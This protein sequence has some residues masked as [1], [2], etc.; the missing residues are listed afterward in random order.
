MKA[1]VFANGV[2][3][4][5]AAI[6]NAL[7]DAAD[8]RIVCANGG[9]L[10]ARAL[11]LTPDIIIGDLDSLTPAQANDFRA[12]GCLVIAAPA[13][14][15][16]TDLELAL[17]HCRDIGAEDVTIV[18]ALGGRIDQ[19]LANVLLLTLPGV[20]GMSLTL[21]DGGQTAR[22]LLPGAHEVFG[23]AGDTLSLIPL[24]DSVDGVT[25]QNLRYPLS[26]ESLPQGPARGIS[27]VM[28][29]DRAE[30]GFRRGK[31]LLVHT[32]GRA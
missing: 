28:L 3:S 6:H 24:G 4:P 19:T 10:Q 14:K 26:D 31:L 1:L 20:S 15:D 12:E 18:G 29:A 22:L 8:S 27:N 2:I 16:E 23:Q 21:V 5:G 13:E 30:L 11:G 17:L 9:A 7:A 25:T 32:V